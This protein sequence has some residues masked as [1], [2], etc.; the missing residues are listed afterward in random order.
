MPE[1][2]RKLIFRSD[3]RVPEPGPR[4]VVVWVN[5]S[6]MSFY[7]LNP[8][9][10]PLKRMATR[11]NGWGDGVS[12]DAARLVVLGDVARHRI[13]HASLKVDESVVV[14]ECGIVGQLTNQ[15]TRCS[16]SMD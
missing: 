12:D 8:M 14:F 11:S 3:V 16:S 4:E 2:G 6:E 1:I 9:D 7:R 5:C 10:D 13:R 15:I